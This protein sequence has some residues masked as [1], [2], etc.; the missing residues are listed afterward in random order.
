VTYTE[1]NTSF[2]FN[3]SDTETIAFDQSANEGQSL[4]STAIG[5]SSSYF[6]ASSKGSIVRLYGVD[7]GNAQISVMAGSVALGKTTRAVGKA[8]IYT[9][10]TAQAAAAKENGLQI[11]GSD[12]KLY[13]VTVDDTDI[14]RTVEV[15]PTFST[16][17]MTGTVVA[18]IPQ[19]QLNA[20]GVNVAAS[21]FAEAA[22]GTE[23]YV[24]GTGDDSSVSVSV[25]G[26]ALDRV[27]ASRQ[28]RGITYKNKTKKTVKFTMTKDQ[29]TAAQTNGIK[30]TGSNFTLHAVS[31]VIVKEQVTPT[32]EE[33]L[34]TSSL[35][36]D[37]YSIDKKIVTDETT[38]KTI[39]GKLKAGSTLT[40]KVKAKAN[41]NYLMLQMGNN[42]T[43]IKKVDFYNDSNYTGYKEGDVV[44]VTVN[45]TQDMLN[46]WK[47]FITDWWSG[48][49]L[50][51]QGN[52]TILTEVK[53]KY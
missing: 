5:I 31:V 2:T 36:M 6:S 39:F 37:D 22:A 10:S 28:T 33:S 41:R 51:C 19:K 52:A 18:G 24:Y 8:Y 49:L 47:K 40:F 29:A 42:Q 4:S 17:E 53:I 35:D 1:S 38:A 3:P 44:T 13:Y 9:L 20:A 12:F 43:L 11:T 27:A 30:I 25:N 45:I 50:S 26:S 14:D 7:N 32:G 21:N 34:L 16:S 48:S 23:V 46:E 15:E